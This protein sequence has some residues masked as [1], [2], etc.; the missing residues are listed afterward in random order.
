MKNMK[1]KHQVDRTTSNTP[2]QGEQEHMKKQANN[3]WRK[4]MEYQHKV[5]R[6]NLKNHNQMDRAN[7]KNQQQGDSNIRNINTWWTGTI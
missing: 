3:R 1:H 4:Q 2:A 6:T 5:D 7:L